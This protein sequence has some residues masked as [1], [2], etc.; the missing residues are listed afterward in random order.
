MVQ[1][2]KKI[3]ELL[4]E[5]K[6]ITEDQ[7][8]KGLQRQKESGDQLGKAII[9]LGFLTEHKLIVVLSDQLDIPYLFLDNYI[10]DQNTVKLIPEDYARHNKIIP[11]FGIEDTL[12]IGIFDPTNIDIIDELSRMTKME[13]EPTLC[14]E[15]EISEALDELYGTSKPM[16]DVLQKIRSMDKDDKGGE[17]SPMIQLVEIM[18]ERAVK[19]GASD[20]H[21]E[22]D[23]KVLRI[24]Y[25]IDGILETMYE[26]PLD[27]QDEIISRVKVMSNLNIT[28]KRLPQDGRFKMSLDGSAFDFRV[29]TLPTYFGENVV[30]RI[31]DQ[32]SINI[33]MDSLGM[34]NEML[35]KYKE[36]VQSPYGIILVTG[37]TGSGKT[38]TLYS[39]MN[40]LNSPEKNIVT[41]EDPVE[42]RL[43]YI[44]QTNVNPKIGLTFANGLRSILRQD[45]DIIMVGEIR[46]AETASIAVQAALTG[47]LVLSTL[48]TNDTVSS[49]TR[50]VDMGVEP[51]LVASSTIAIVA[52][53]LVRKICTRCK[54]EYEPELELLEDLNLASARKKLKF[55]RAEGCKHCRKTGYKGRVGLYEIL[56]ITEGIRRLIVQNADYD[57]ILDKALEEGLIQLKYDGIRKV[58][59]G[60]TTIDEVL[61][62]T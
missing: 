22:P 48:H 26:H 41:I 13:I 46:D 7:L 25:R 56:L 57:D 20:I 55:Y 14:A 9:D 39:A 43:P 29:S 19:L 1:K 27:L 31:L 10:F 4:L 12:T 54:V 28:E 32:G 58:L 2:R 35:K 5:A 38:T 30:I 16:D 17:E 23:E 53:R 40:S 52:Q 61:R 62:V 24:R 3:G 42:Y 33:E 8:Q 11:L 21:I 59:Q 60:F 49:A 50:L 37:P 15:S 47:H 34:S 45:P 44:R 18:F 6:A 51:F 36:V